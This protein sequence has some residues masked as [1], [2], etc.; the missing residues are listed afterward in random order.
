MT[1]GIIMLATVV[2]TL[3]G[4]F[5]A[6]RYKRYAHIF[7]GLTAGTLLAVIFLEI[8]PEI[9][10]IQKDSPLPFIYVLIGFILFHIFE[11][12]FSLHHS[13]HD[14]H[15]HHTHIASKKVG[16]IALI[17]HSFFDG[18]S[19]AVAYAVSPEF[20]FLLALAVIA[21]DFSD[22][23]NTVSLTERSKKSKMYLALDALAPVAG[24]LVGSAF[25]FP[26]AFLGPILSICA[27]VLLYVCT[28]DVLPE[29]HCDKPRHTAEHLIALCAGVLYIVIIMGVVTT[30]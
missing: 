27:G 13:H 9:M 16:V 28:G 15:D 1:L 10:D 2:S 8:L 24:V 12:I 30:V 26:D 6:F 29:A 25:V 22:G 4:G 11:K 21:H 17:V 23:F 19:I 7:T 3:L 18:F 20:G 14:E 5:V